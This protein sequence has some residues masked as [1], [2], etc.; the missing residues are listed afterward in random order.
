MRNCESPRAPTGAAPRSI[1]TRTR[2]AREGPAGLQTTR[3]AAR[4]GRAPSAARAVSA[5]PPLQLQVRKVRKCGK[6]ATARVSSRRPVRNGSAEV[7]NASPRR[8][9]QTFATVHLRSLCRRASSLQAARGSNHPRPSTSGRTRVHLQ[10]RPASERAAPCRFPLG[11]TAGIRR[12]KTPPAPGPRR[13]A[14]S[15]L[16]LGADFRPD[17]SSPSAS[18]DDCTRYT[19]TFSKPGGE[20]RLP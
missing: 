20:A 6:R 4:S 10:T 15:P 14:V 1:R 7:R 16:A 13:A 12:A 2:R 17:H 8:T 3:P 9:L 19:V 5:A 18:S 11:P